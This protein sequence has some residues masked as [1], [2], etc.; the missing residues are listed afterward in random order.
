MPRT[1]LPEWTPLDAVMITWPYEGSDWTPWLAEV[2][3]CYQGLLAAITRHTRA[4]VLCHPVIEL[5]AL[6]ERCR[7]A[8]VDTGL[9]RFEVIEVNDTWVRDYGPISVLNGQGQ[10]ELLDFR[11]NAWGGKYQANADDAVNAELAR[12]GVLVAPV[13][14][15]EFVL[16]GGA[17]DSDGTGSLLTTEHCLMQ[18]TRNPGLSRDEV[19]GRLREFLGVRQVHWLQ[20]GHLAGDDTDS[21]VDTLARFCGADTI[22]HASCDNPDDPHFEPLQAMQAELLQLRSLDGKPYR[23]LPLPMPAPVF[24]PEGERLPATYANFL[25]VNDA[26]LMP[27]YGCPQDEAALATLDAA[28][29]NYVIEPVDCAVLVQQFGSLHCATMQLPRGAY[30]HVD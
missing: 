6:V 12:R 26:V 7:T 19:E 13:V 10:L 15:A 20:S 3:R 17:I 30:A 2:D 18:S 24:S 16:E 4:L 5:D 8:G 22:V 28:F 21:H 1:F 14:R 27:T 9:C 25:V 23:L 11:F 29:P